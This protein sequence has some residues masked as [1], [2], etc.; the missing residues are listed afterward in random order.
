MPKKKSRKVSLDK[1]VLQ[2]V[3]EDTAQGT[4]NLDMLRPLNAV[5]NFP[6]LGSKGGSGSNFDFE[7]FY[8]QGFDDLVNRAYYTTKA[9]LESAIAS[10]SSQNTIFHYAAKGFTYLTDFLPLYR[11]HKEHDLSQADISQALMDS[12]RIH[13]KTLKKKRAKATCHTAL[14]KLSTPK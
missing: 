6:A 7:P 8:G 11:Q 4:G 2:H 13:L 10:G 14:K 5:I 9:L 3:K 12:F 1:F